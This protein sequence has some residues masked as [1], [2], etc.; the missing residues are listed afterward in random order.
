MKIE[1]KGE[2]FV[3]MSLNGKDVVISANGNV[4]T[5]GKEFN[6]FSEVDNTKVKEDKDG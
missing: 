1:L 6:I 4:V 5:N 2:E 3:E